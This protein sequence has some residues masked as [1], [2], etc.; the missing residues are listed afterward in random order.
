MINLFPA[1]FDNYFIKVIFLVHATLLAL[2]NLANSSYSYT[3]VYTS[4]NS[5]FLLTILLA[6]LVNENTDV[7]L[8]AT[9]FN[10]ICIA[11]DIILLIVS[12]GGTSYIGLFATLLIVLNLIIRPLSAILLLKNYSARAGVEDPT[13]G[14]LEVHVQAPT[15]P[16][17]RSAYQ[18]IDEPNQTLP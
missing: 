17:A 3:L 18:N 7:I 4:Y 5:L 8:I 15:V 11:I 9:A 10:V 14:L 6:I 13:S 16:R 12:A 2:S 1:L